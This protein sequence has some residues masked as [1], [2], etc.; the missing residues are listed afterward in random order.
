MKWAIQHI[1]QKLFFLYTMIWSKIWSSI[2]AIPL[3]LIFLLVINRGITNFY[4]FLILRTCYII[5]LNYRWQRVLIL[6]ITFILKYRKLV[7][8][9]WALCL[10]CFSLRRFL[11]ILESLKLH[12]QI[13]KWIR[14][15]K[16]TSTLWYCFCITWVKL[17]RYILLY[18]LILRI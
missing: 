3:L 12:I 16:K 5:C 18:F 14:S 10:S 1:Q 4:W 8:R 15:W 9:I 2:E 17:I 7:L 11:L 13:L 6:L